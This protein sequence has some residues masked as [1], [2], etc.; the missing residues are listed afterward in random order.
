M[1]V[2]LYVA[3]ATANV[4]SGQPHIVDFVKAQVLE[5]STIV[6]LISSIYAGLCKSVSEKTSS[7]QLGE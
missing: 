7:R 1:C 2:S 3:R 4:Y 5:S 6:V